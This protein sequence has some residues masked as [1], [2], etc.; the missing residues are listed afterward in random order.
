LFLPF[1]GNLLLG[2]TSRDI[3]LLKT[4]DT[5][6]DFDEQSSSSSSSSSARQQTATSSTDNV[7]S[8][9][10]AMAKEAYRRAANQRAMADLIVKAKQSVP[11]FDVT[12]VVTSYSG[13]RARSSIGDFCIEPS[14]NVA[15]FINVMGIDSPVSF[16]HYSCQML[17][18]LFVALLLTLN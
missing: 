11:S 3:D 8:D 9:G 7:E 12:Q 14:L 4:D 15:G 13:L 5:F 18:L 17:T 2:P 6:D 10:E 16:C 1:P